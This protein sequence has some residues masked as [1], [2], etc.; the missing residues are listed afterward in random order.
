MEISEATWAPRIKN[1]AKGSQ[2]R[3][4]KQ[5]EMKQ[6]VGDTIFKNIT[7]YLPHAKDFLKSFLVS[8]KQSTNIAQ[9]SL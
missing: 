1:T 4:N 9:Q 8:R 2:L 6:Q 7:N 3:P 5:I